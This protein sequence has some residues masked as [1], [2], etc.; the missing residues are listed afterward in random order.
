MF[1]FLCIGL[2]TRLKHLTKFGPSP[3]WAFTV[4]VLVHVPL[5]F[6]LS[7]V[8]FRDFRMAVQ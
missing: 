7:T 4:G 2:T 5:G 1:T 3:F 8:V 6:S